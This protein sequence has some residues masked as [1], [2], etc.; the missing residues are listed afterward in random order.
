MTLEEA[1]RILR[2]PE[3]RDETKRV[4][5]LRRAVDWAEITIRAGGVE[6]AEAEAIV[7]AVGARAEELFPGSQ[8]TFAIVYGVRMRRILAEVFGQPD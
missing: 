5:F 4:Y 8:E 1:I 6:R 7:D 3:G 2:S